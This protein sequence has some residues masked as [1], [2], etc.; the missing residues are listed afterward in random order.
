MIFFIIVNMIQKK[1]CSEKSL[2][3]FGV[4]K[5]LQVVISKKI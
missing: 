4:G 5:V 1:I 2:F 3:Q